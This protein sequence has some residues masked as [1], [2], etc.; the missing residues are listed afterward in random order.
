MATTTTA[1][2]NFSATVTALVMQQLEDILAASYPHISPANH[3]RARMGKGKNQL[4]FTAYAQLA[5]VTT[6][7]TEGT[8]PTDQALA[9]S[10]D[11]ITASQVGWTAAL[12]DLA[13]EE[14]PHDLVAVAAERI[15]DQAAHSLDVIVR[16]ILAAGA[17]VKLSNGAARS[18]VSAKVTGALVKEM[19]GRLQDLNVPKFSDG[20]YRCFISPR[21]VFDLQTDTA[22]GGWM[23]IMKYTD[24]GL[25]KLLTHEV[26]AYAGVRFMISTNAKVFATAGASSVDVLSTFFFGPNAYAVGDL[27]SL[28]AYFVPPG[29][30]HSDP[31][32]QK[33]IVGAK[34]ALGAALL[35]ANGVRYQRLESAATVLSSGA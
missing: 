11:V 13:S 12:S 16:D 4:T 1:T 15:A 14:S 20:F 6:A 17:S 19:A 21:V 29:G 34:A 26:G 10:T 35:D 8:P 32:A 22:N 9:I 33:A 5:A 31:I 28:R 2:T 30:D 25:P 27:Q 7:L 3:V 24:L 23:D 18:A